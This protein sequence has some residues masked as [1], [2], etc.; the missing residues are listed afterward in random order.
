MR[1]QRATQVKT[2]DKALHKGTEMS[3]KPILSNRTPVHPI[4][5]LQKAVGNRAVNHLIQTKL[6]IGQPGDVYEQEADRVADMV[7]RMPELQATMEERVSRQGGG[8]HI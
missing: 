3:N 4:L 7:M 2:S 1:H 5:Q 6:K 8:I